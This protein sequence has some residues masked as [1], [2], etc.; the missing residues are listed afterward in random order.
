MGFKMKK[1]YMTQG[2]K[3]HREAVKNIKLNRNMDK[4]SLS[5]GRAGSSPFQKTGSP[6][7]ALDDRIARTEAKT[8]KLQEK[9][10]AKITKGKA[11]AQAK[12][13]KLTHR[14]DVKEAKAGVKEAK[15]KYMGRGR[16]MAKAE[17]LRAKAAAY[18]PP[19]ETEEVTED[20]TRK[21]VKKMDEKPSEKPSGAEIAS[22][23]TGALGDKSAAR[24]AHVGEKELP[25]YTSSYEKVKDKYKDA[26]T[27]D[28][29][30]SLEN[31]AKQKIWNE[32]SDQLDKDRNAEDKTTEVSKDTYIHLLASGLS[33]GDVN[34]QRATGELHNK[35]NGR[36]LSVRE[37]NRKLSGFTS[38]STEKEFSP[39]YDK[40]TFEQPVAEEEVKVEE[41][42]AKEETTV[43]EKK[44]EKPKKKKST[45][46]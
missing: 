34:F 46:K 25:T 2:T 3:G 17:K 14:A 36:K 10:E 33:T 29:W 37:L 27:F 44:D 38:A 42:P 20:T 21:I 43:E 18:T 40:E 39:D 19:G 32:V 31:D 11:K 9:K 41:T 45:P 16:K 26:A 23:V 13:D 22:L 4:T 24:A 8:A 35:T 7:K 6:M 30:S 5:D 1:P 12:A 15:G 28:G